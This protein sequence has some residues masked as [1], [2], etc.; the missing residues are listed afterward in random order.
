[1]SQARLRRQSSV[2]SRQS[3]IAIRAHGS[4]IRAVP[5]YEYRCRTCGLEFET[6]VRG[7]EQP[8]CAECGSS[9]LERCLSLFGVSTES[10]RQTSRGKAKTAMKKANRD[11]AIAT[12]EEMERH[13]H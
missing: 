5:I 6:L 4:R 8:A 3:P 12:R 2:V 1:M 10:T 13:H 11:K 9:D 7:I